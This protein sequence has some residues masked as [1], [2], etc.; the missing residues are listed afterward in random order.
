MSHLYLI[1]QIAGRTVAIDSDQV[2]SVVDIGE[3]TAIPRAA[4]HVRGLAALR[5]RVV[6]VVDTQS[7]LGL[8]SHGSEARRAVI[9]LIDGHHY[10]LL[11]DAL[12]DVAPFDPLPLASGVALGNAWRHVGRGIVERDGEP[13][14]VVDLASLVPG[15]AVAAE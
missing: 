1:A 11:V 8:D 12:D 3:V 2:E 4:D 14:L 9:T 15:H 6:T 7:A 10:A 5:S 13:I